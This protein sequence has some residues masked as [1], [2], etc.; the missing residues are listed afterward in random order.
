MDILPGHN[1]LNVAGSTPFG[2][3]SNSIGT[4]FGVMPIRIIL[5]R[6]EEVDNLLLDPY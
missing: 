3:V 4:T 1:P 2:Q 5:F 6:N